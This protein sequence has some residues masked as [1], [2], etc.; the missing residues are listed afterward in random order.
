VEL[1]S[2]C[3]NIISANCTL[4]QTMDVWTTHILFLSS[5]A[6]VLLTNN[7]IQ[8]HTQ[9]RNLN[10][11]SNLCHW[12]VMHLFIYDI[13]LRYLVYDIWFMISGLLWILYI[14]MSSISNMRFNCRNINNSKYH[15]GLLSAQ[16]HISGRTSSNHCTVTYKWTDILKP[17]H[18]D[19]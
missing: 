3:I 15:K 11:L 9:T 2:T 5:Y 10:K 4:C 7:I 14:L 19:I 6:S 17:L 12:Y 13:W 16:W 18:N 8:M 1:F